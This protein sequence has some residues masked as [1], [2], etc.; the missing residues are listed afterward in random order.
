[1]KTELKIF[2]TNLKSVRTN[3]G[4]TQKE[5]AIF[6]GLTERSYQRY[7]NRDNT[8]PYETLIKIADYINVSID[9]L[10]GRTDDPTFKPVKLK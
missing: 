3:S 9:Y 4:I 1:M 7:E 2:G 8:P 5:F 10:L 6:L